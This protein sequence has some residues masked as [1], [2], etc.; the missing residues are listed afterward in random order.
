[1][2]ISFPEPTITPITKPFWNSI[3]QKKFTLQ[4]CEN[5]EQWI[6]YPRAHCPHC[7]G[8]RLTWR[9]ATGKGRL[10]TWSV[11]HRAGHP[12]WQSLTPY[13]VGIVELEEGPSLLTHLLIREKELRYQLPVEI[14]YHVLNE[15][16]LPFFK[17]EEGES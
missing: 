16:Q 6:F 14:S 1:M 4:Q 5:C 2:N 7:F 3:E 9:E 12:A 13:A 15:R 17:R 8:N 10:K 11:V